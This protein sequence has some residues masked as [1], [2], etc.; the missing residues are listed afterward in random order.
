MKRPCNYSRLYHCI[1]QT[2]LSK[3]TQVSVNSQYW[4][5]DL[6]PWPSER[7]VRFVTPQRHSVILSN[8]LRIINSLIA[9]TEMHCVFC[10]AVTQ[11]LDTI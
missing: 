7:E 10:A 11:S 1:R 8:L 9:I 2:V 3:T 4:D 5:W 6:N